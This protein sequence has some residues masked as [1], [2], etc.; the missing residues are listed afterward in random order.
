MGRLLAHEAVEQGGPLRLDGPREL[1]RR[2]GVDLGLGVGVGLGL[3]LGLVLGL[4]LGI[5]LGLGLSLSR[6][7]LVGLEV[8]DHPYISPISPLYLP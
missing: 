2:V 3:V 5:G 8:V 7:E 6:L 4:G 1:D